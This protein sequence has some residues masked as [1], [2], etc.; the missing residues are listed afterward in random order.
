M[1]Y[2]AARNQGIIAPARA[3]KIKI[4]IQMNA[5]LPGRGSFRS[6]SLGLSTLLKPGRGL[7]VWG[8]MLEPGMLRGVLETAIFI[9]PFWV[10]IYL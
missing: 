7:T 10:A 3:D 1:P 2:M 5:V 4:A 6:L 9:L 8:V